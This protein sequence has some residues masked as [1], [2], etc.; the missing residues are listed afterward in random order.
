MESIQ[1]IKRRIKSVGNTE[2]ITK[3]MGMV[4]G[5]KMRKSQIVALN[6]RP[7]SIAGMEILREISKRVP[8]LP[9]LMTT[10]TETNKT[11]LVLITADKGLAGSLNS[12][13]FRNFE[14]RFGQDAGEYLYAAVGKKAEDYLTRKNLMIQK[15]FIKFGDY[16]K[17]EETQVFADFIINGFLENKWTKVIAISTH[18]RTTLRQ[19][20]L[21]RELLPISFEKIEEDIREIVPEYGRYSGNN[22][23]KISSTQDYEYLIEGGPEGNAQS[24]IED[25][26]KHL[27]EMVIYHLIL[28]SNAS[29]HSARMVAMKNASDNA[30]ELKDNLS[31]IYNKSRQAGITQELAEITA[32][33]NS[34]T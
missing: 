15:S 11:L 13:I 19:D 2:Q 21:V 9:R 31:L 12:N 30:G 3:A 33:A 20:V 7:Y 18:F 28:E 25:L 5:N 16:A 14:R 32:G 23:L 27:V 17:P 6:S 10:S 29:E 34:N 4:A 26:T 8:R 22:E 1:S 24:I